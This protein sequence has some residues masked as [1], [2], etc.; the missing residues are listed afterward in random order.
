MKVAKDCCACGR[1]EIETSES[2]GRTARSVEL[3]AAA[4]F[5]ARGWK[6][7]RTTGSSLCPQCVREL[8]VEGV[9]P[10]VDELRMS[11]GELHFA[12]QRIGQS[13]ERPDLDA[14]AIANIRQA[15]EA[16]EGAAA[17]TLR[18]LALSP[19]HAREIAYRAREAMSRSTEQRTAPQPTPTP[20]P[21]RPSIGRI[22]HL[23]SAQ[24]DNDPL[25]EAAIVTAVH[26][27]DVVD[28]AVFRPNWKDNEAGYGI[29]TVVF[30]FRCKLAPESVRPGEIDACGLWSWPA[31]I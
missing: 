20:A 10:D 5:E 9:V 30:E 19:E 13:L 12:L 21:M 16:V 14:G 8:A 17:E 2:M 24:P 22:V 27:D 15:V 6:T 28:L 7:L 25:V 3:E 23:T 4:T 31:R 18:G 1:T 11:V 26:A 29:G